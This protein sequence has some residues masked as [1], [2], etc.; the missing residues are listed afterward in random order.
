MKI[1]GTFNT[2]F[3]LDIRDG[4][5]QEC[6][7]FFCGLGDQAQNDLGLWLIKPNGFAKLVIYFTED[8]EKK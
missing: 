2:F 4:E 8:N 1:M 7:W 5:L 3:F 6:I